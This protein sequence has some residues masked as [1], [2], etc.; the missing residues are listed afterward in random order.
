MHEVPAYIGLAVPGRPLRSLIAED[1]SVAGVCD[2]TGPELAVIVVALVRA[3]SA[4]RRE[5]LAGP[6]TL[7]PPH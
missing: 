4:R 5:P 2:Q 1:R 6:G 7:W 3:G